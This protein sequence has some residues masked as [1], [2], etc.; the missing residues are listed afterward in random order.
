MCSFS[1]NGIQP[2][3]TPRKRDTKNNPKTSSPKK[4]QGQG[5]SKTKS[6][7]TSFRRKPPTPPTPTSA[8]KGSGRTSSSPPSSNKPNPS[9]D[10]TLSAL[11]RIIP[12]SAEQNTPA[13]PPPPPSP[14][15]GGHRRGPMPQH[16]HPCGGRDVILNGTYIVR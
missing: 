5:K 4:K 10:H 3:K 16:R 1:E 15:P 14:S 13:A 8:T 11:D 12:V 9:R 2:N 7:K 6:N